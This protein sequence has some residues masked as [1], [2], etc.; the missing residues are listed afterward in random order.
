MADKHPFWNKLTKAIRDSAFDNELKKLPVNEMY[1]KDTEF[2][3]YERLKVSHELFN[4]FPN[5]IG[6]YFTGIVNFKEK[7]IT[8]G[9]TD[10][11]NLVLLNRKYNKIFTLPDEYMYYT[12]IAN[13][14]RIK[15]QYFTAECFDLLNNDGIVCISIP[16]SYDGDIESKQLVIDYCQE[17][18]I[19]IFIDVAYCGLTDP[20]VIN[21]KKTENT[22]FAFSFSKTLGLAFN[23][24]GV[25]YSDEP[26]VSMSLM[27]KIGYV[28][29][30]GALA[31]LRLMKKFPCN[32]VYQT[33]KD[34]CNDI[35][36]EYNLTPTKCILFGRTPSDDKFGIAE[37]Y[38]LK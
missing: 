14:L 15:Q 11:L 25:L 34:Q 3:F 20:G 7:Y 33:Y 38:K 26:V 28:N 29:L 13:S 8:N 18:G 12:Y 9:N 23:K 31:A 2:N 16:A 27:N 5:W 37:Y 24:V 32:Y 10:A 21:I 6:D 4:T 1:F 19:P 22:F 30:S 35:C 36:N 17:N